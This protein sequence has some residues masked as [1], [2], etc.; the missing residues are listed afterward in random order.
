MEL[1]AGVSTSTHTYAGTSYANPHAL[2]TLSNGQ[3]TSTFAYDNNGNVVQK[4]V[5]G[6]T[7]TYVWDYAN[8]LIR[9]GLKNLHRTISGV[10]A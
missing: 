4:T 6:I 1:P 7:T 8:R 10:S 9:A 2:T 5:D 3:S